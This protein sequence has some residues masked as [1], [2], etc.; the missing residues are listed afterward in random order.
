MA[1]PQLIK[2]YLKKGSKWARV[3]AKKTDQPKEKS[4]L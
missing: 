2:V 1:K 3:T 4:G